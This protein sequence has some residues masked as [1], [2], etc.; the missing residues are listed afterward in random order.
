MVEGGDFLFLGHDAV[1]Q[2][3]VEFHA[4]PYASLKFFLL[5]VQLV[6][7]EDQLVIADTGFLD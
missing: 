4:F 6:Q 5:L 2:L 7:A 3:L 1:A